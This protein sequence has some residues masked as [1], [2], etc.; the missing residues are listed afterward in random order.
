MTTVKSVVMRNH[1]RRHWMKP[2]LFCTLCGQFKWDVETRKMNGLVNCKMCTRI[3]R[4]FGYKRG[5]PMR[6]R[7]MSII[8]LGDP[9]IAKKRIM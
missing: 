5:G 4:H 1:H 7:E 6:T 3:A 2:N 9:G 8:K